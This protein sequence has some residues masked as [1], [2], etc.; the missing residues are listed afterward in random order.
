[1]PPTDAITLENYFCQPGSVD[2]RNGSS[3]WATGFPGWVET[4]IA[5]NGLT[6]TKLFGIAAGQLYDAT[7]TGAIG[8]ALVSGLSNSRFEYTHIDTPA[9]AYLYAM[10]ASDSPLLYNGSTWQQ[11]TGI[12]API[13]ITGVTTSQLRN[14]WV[15]KN[16]LFAIQDGTLT[17]WYLPIQ[18]VGGAA[19]PLFLQSYFAKGGQ[20]QAGFTVSITDASSTDDY[21]GFLST[22]GELVMFRGTDPAFSGSFGMVGR[23]QMGRPVGRR[24]FFRLDGDTIII[25]EDGFM[26]VSAAMTAERD[27]PAAALSAKIRP[28]INSDVQ[29][30]GSNWGWQ[31]IVYPTGNKLII[32]TPEVS[33]SLSHQHVMSTTT[34]GW[35]RFT[36]WNA[37]CFETQGSALYFGTS[38]VIVQADMAGVGT[39]NGVAI[40]ARVKPAFSYFDSEGQQ[41]E[42]KMVRPIYA[43]NGTPTLSIIVNTDFADF[44]P[45][46]PLTPPPLSGPAWDVT[47]WDTAQWGG[48]SS[49]VSNWYGADGVGFSG[50]LNMTVISNGTTQQLQS[51]DYL[52]EIAQGSVL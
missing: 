9:G 5:Y 37:A 35:S 3:N 18:S 38:G 1:M 52:Y 47:P 51:I 2:I 34:K 24:P 26:P 46:Y 14:P 23:F 31:G 8:A 21:V 39:D 11:V 17:A 6:G 25:N 30:Y 29:T 32:N 42:F 48:T 12:S 36:G 50:T 16:R 27:N 19:Q 10:N 7:L 40:T 13:A 22:M 20:L 44:A 15:W 28:L 33:D 41:K 4:I 43:S 45:A 49:Q